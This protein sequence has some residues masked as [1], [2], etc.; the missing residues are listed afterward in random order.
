MN[1]PHNEF[2]VTPV[3]QINYPLE[4]EWEY[5]QTVTQT[6]VEL[7]ARITGDC[8]PIHINQNYINE[9][10]AKRVAQGKEPAFVSR[11]V[12]GALTSALVITVLGTKLPDPVILVRSSNE[13]KAPVYIGDTLTATVYVSKYH[14]SKNGVVCFETW[15]R[16]QH[17]KLVL[18]G[19]AQVRVP[20]N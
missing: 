1:H 8:N 9:W 10:N 2:E 19:S 7:F 16:N 18:A 20:T 17:G 5:T 6:D 11:L 4:A 13:W 15:V 12:P 14:P 3:W